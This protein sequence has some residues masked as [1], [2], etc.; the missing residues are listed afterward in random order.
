MKVYIIRRKII[1]LVA[2]Y[3]LMTVHEDEKLA[4]DEVERLKA[5]KPGTR[6]I[7]SERE[8]L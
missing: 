5:K 7:I 4:K 3:A 6:Y 1:G 2:G 8:V